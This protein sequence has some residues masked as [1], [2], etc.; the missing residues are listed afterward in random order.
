MTTRTITYMLKKRSTSCAQ[1]FIH[2]V[3][4]KL[5]KHQKNSKT[6]PT[7]NAKTKNPEYTTKAIKSNGKDHTSS[8]QLLKTFRTS[9]KS[10]S[11]FI[12]ETISLSYLTYITT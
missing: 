3:H 12:N 10:R 11:L 9:Q 8:V 2:Q 1:P 5:K 4:E 6:T 7:H